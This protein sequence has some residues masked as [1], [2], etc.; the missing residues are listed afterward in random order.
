[1]SYVP[2]QALGLDAN[3]ILEEL[4]DAPSRNE[5]IQALL[6]QLFRHIDREEFQKA[7]TL[8]PRI[9]EKIGPSDPE[10][11]RARSLMSFLNESE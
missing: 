9:R 6:H 3:R 10:L 4:M 2:D 11:V 8:I 5:E 7:R 1:M